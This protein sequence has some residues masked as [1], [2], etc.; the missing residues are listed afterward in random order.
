[1]SKQGKVIDFF[2]HV[3]SRYRLD[4]MNRAYGRHKADHHRRMKE[5]DKKNDPDK[6]G[7]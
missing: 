6:S 5:R 2:E 4:A 3:S 1:M 7:T